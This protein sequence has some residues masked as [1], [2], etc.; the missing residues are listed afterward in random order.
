MPVTID[1]RHYVDLYSPTTGDRVRLG[2][3]DLWLEAERALASYRR[4]LQF[5]GGTGPTSGTKATTCTPGARHIELML[6][7]TDALPV[8][9]GLT[10]KGNSSMAEG[11]TDQIRAGAIGLK[12]HEDWGSAPPAIDCCLAVA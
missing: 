8:N 3:T 2:D 5:G 9:V 11:L 4:E 12:L 1:R 6:K 7:A 10:G